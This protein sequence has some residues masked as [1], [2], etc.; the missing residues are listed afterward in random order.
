MTGI[1]KSDNYI[2]VLSATRGERE[3]VMLK[4]L[5]RELKKG[6]WFTLKP[7][8]VP[9]DNQVWVRGDYDRV[10]KTYRVS[11]FD[12]VNRERSFKSDK[13]VYVDFIF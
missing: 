5:V 12:D 7:I 4:K 6:E 10:S 8:E 13:V 2:A 9:K 1:E 3:R 11:N